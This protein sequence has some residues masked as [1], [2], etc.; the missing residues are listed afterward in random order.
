M[1]ASAR[2]KEKRLGRFS[3]PDFKDDSEQCSFAVHPCTAHYRIFALQKCAAVLQR[4]DTASVPCLE[5]RPRA[6]CNER[7]ARS[8]PRRIYVRL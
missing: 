8:S 5:G 7:E 4:Y 6:T 2:I 1:K 3:P